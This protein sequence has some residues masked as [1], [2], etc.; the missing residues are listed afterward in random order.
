[1][2]SLLSIALAIS[3]LQAADLSGGKWALG[4]KYG[5]GSSTIIDSNITY[6]FTDTHVLTL[7]PKNGL[8]I[9]KKSST[10]DGVDIYSTYENGP[11]FVAKMTND[12]TWATSGFPI[13]RAE[14]AAW[15]QDSTRQLNVGLAWQKPAKISEP[16]T[17]KFTDS[18]DNTTY[19]TVTF[20]G[21]TWMAQDLHY[22][23]PKSEC[24]WS[25]S[26]GKT[27]CEVGVG[28]PAEERDIACPAKWHQ[29]SNAEWIALAS[30]V[31]QTEKFNGEMKQAFWTDPKGFA[32]GQGQIVEIG[33]NPQYWTS[34]YSGYNNQSTISISADK[35]F[36]LYPNSTSEPRNAMRCV[37]N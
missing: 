27:S 17:G 36:Q 19:P 3:A 8:E 9:L 25:N 6:L 31:I 35:G 5:F 2:K 7:S 28:Y 12:H 14:I 24:M 37:Q 22:R 29:P 15:N 21:K 18:R 16:K 30:A 23:T 26:L 20:G 11:V 34:S 10:Q 1:M 33:N 13:D 4:Q 32:V